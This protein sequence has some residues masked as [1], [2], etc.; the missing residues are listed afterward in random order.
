MTDSSPRASLIASHPAARPGASRVKATF[1]DLRVG[2]YMTNEQGE[3]ARW[4]EVVEIRRPGRDG[5]DVS[6]LFEIPEPVNLRSMETRY[7]IERSDET[8]VVVDR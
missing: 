5:A 4:V 7:W 2:D 6:V 8:P 3:Q 1:A